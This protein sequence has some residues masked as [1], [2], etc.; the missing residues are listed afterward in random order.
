MNTPSTSIIS[1]ALIGRIYEARYGTAGDKPAS[2]PSMSDTFSPPSIRPVTPKVWQRSTVDLLF[3]ET[4]SCSLLSCNQ[5]SLLG[6]HAGS[7][8]EEEYCLW[9]LSPSSSFCVRA[10]EVKQGKSTFLVLICPWATKKKN[11]P[12]TTADK[13]LCVLFSAIVEV[14]QPWS[15]NF[16]WKG[17]PWLHSKKSMEF[18]KRDRKLCVLCQNYSE[19][20]LQNGRMKKRSEVRVLLRHT[21]LC[22]M[23]SSGGILGPRE[24]RK[25]EKWE[26]HRIL[27]RRGSRQRYN[28]GRHNM[29]SAT[30]LQ[31]GE[32]CASRLIMCPSR[33]H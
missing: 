28:A 14:A 9:G 8:Q 24:R 26:A 10:A 19:S 22:F 16:F 25:D 23:E 33:G 1:F 20:M 31:K 6:R 11:L 32:K 3:H 13:S 18:L 30:W 17:S 15:L 2:L 7:R 27:M 12:V 4:P 21:P 29:C 5:I